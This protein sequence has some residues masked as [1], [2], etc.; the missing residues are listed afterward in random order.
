MYL[1][2]SACSILY[3]EG[4]WGSGGLMLRWFSLLAWIRYVVVGWIRFFSKLLFSS[5]LSVGKGSRSCLH[6]SSV[7]YLHQTPHSIWPT[8]H[9]GFTTWKVVSLPTKAKELSWLCTT[10]AHS[11]TTSLSAYRHNTSTNKGYL[12]SHIT[13]MFLV[14]HVTISTSFT[15]LLYLWPKKM[16]WRLYWTNEEVVK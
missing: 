3:G 14:L 9:S 5:S 12:I 15:W 13:K 7:L 11:P 16:N 4:G 2:F 8:F 10:S 6:I 1:L